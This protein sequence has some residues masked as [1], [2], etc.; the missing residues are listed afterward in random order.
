MLELAFMTHLQNFRIV[1]ATAL[2]CEVT[3]GQCFTEKKKKMQLLRRLRAPAVVLPRHYDNGW[4]V[5]CTSA[6]RSKDLQLFMLS[7]LT[8]GNDYDEVVIVINSKTQFLVS[9]VAV[10]KE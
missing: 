4:D 10:Y 3:I 2:S 9:L 6:F 5:A 1:I 7:C 8:K